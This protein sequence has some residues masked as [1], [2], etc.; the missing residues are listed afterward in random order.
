MVTNQVNRSSALHK[1]VTISLPLPLRMGRVNCYLIETGIGYVLIDT[2]TSMNRKVMVKELESAGCKPGLLELIILTHGDFDHSGN[3]AYLRKV[4]NCKIGMHTDDS[5]MVELGDM[6]VNR[7]QP[8]LFIRKFVPLLTG[9]GVNERFK[10]DILVD[11][12]FDLSGYDFHARIIT[13]P[14]HSKGSIGILTANGDLYCGDL[15]ENQTKPILNS[16]MDDLE[17]ANKTVEKLKK[18]KNLTVYPGHGEPFIIY[19]LTNI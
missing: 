17:A 16:I 7:K 10:P 14:G 15:F 8:N 5:G 4:F 6:F 9:F 13:L 19:Q 12:G 1:Q 11:E 3:A 2:G 18:Y